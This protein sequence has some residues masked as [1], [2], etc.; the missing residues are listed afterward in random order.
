MSIS[1]NAY[2]ETSS[3]SNSL[4]VPV[5]PTS[6]STPIKGRI[7]YDSTS[8]TLQYANGVVWS[9][10]TA[11]G[12]VGG[13]LTGTMPDPG[14]ASTT[15]TPGTYNNVNLTV[16]ADGR[17]TSA[18]NGASGGGSVTN[19]ATGTGLTGGP[20]TSTGTISMAN[21]AV[22]PGIY[23]NGSNVPTV[24]V[25]QQGQITNLSTS[26]AGGVPVSYY[27]LGGADTLVNNNAT[28]VFNVNPIE[29]TGSMLNGVWTCNAAGIYSVAFSSNTV[30]DGNTARGQY[31]ILL[32]GSYGTGISIGY[33][34][35]G[36]DTSIVPLM[37]SIEGTAT[38]TLFINLIVGSTIQV[39]VTTGETILLKGSSS[40][41][42]VTL[43]ITKMS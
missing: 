27:Y 23:G 11:T 16:G 31:E 3:S 14:L 12:P 18:A 7:A 35:A 28:I 19:I 17:I 6:T 43:A 41:P 36:N 24:T 13:V 1:K 5:L 21:T 37:T 39:A 30:P 38:I 40:G 29:N 33:C 8:G 20:I 25:N 9:Q 15:V 10:T 42:A 32:D 26:A 4:L 2:I 22:T 34:T